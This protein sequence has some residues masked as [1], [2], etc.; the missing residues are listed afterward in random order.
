MHG[1]ENHGKA[2]QYALFTN[3][4]HKVY[5]DIPD[6]NLDTV[7]KFWVKNYKVHNAFNCSQAKANMYECV[8]YDVCP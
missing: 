8:A 3:M 2:K 5:Y 6:S 4:D 1:T 7:T